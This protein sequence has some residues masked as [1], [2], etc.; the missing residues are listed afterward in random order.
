MWIRGGGTP[1]TFGE[2]DKV[3]GLERLDV[4]LH[5]TIAVIQK[6]KVSRILLTNPFKGFHWTL[7]LLVGAAVFSAPIVGTIAAQAAPDCG[8][9]VSHSYDAKQNITETH[10]A[11]GLTILSKEVHAAPVVYFS[12]WY[13]VGSRN[14][15]SGETGLSH[16]LEHMMF[17]GT[18][19]LPPGS[20]DHLFL[21]NGGEINASTANDRTEY[22]ELIASDRLELAVRVEADRME[23]SAFDPLQLK[24]E[25]TVVRSELEGDNNDPNYDLYTN[26]FEPMEFVESPY[27]WPA[28]GWRSDVEAVANRRD[29]IYAYYK[30]HYM[31]NNAFVVMVGDFDTKKAV[32][33]CQKYFGVYSPGHLAQ[34]HI[35]PEPPQEGERRAIL[36]RPGTTAAIIM[37]FHVP[38]VGTKDHYVFDVL[39]TLLSGGRSDRLYQDLVETGI[40][41]EADADNED[42]IDPWAFTF[43]VSVRN[44]VTT[45]AAEDAI[46]KEITRLQTTPVSEDELQRAIND[47]EASYVYTNDS[48]SSQADLIGS[49]EIN[50]SYRYQDTYLDKIKAITAA[51]IQAAAQKY[52]IANNRCVAIY[53]PTPLPPGA[54]PPAQAGEKDFGAAPPITDPRQKAIIAALD[55]KFNSG[56]STTSSAQLPKPTRVV[57]PNGLTLIVEENHANPTVAI[58]GRVI[59]GSMFDPDNRWGTAGL[60]AAMLSRGTTSAD[61][62][63]LALKLESV[64]ANV[65]FASGKEETSIGGICQSKDFGLTI[66]TMADELRN[67]IFPTDQLEKLRGETLSGLEEAR[68]DTGGTGGAGTDATISFMDALY[69]KGHP[70]W[71]PTIDEQEAAVKGL[72]QS[73]LMSFYQQ[74]YRPDTTILVVVGDVKTADVVNEIKSQFGDWTNPS[75]PTPTIAIPDVPLPTTAPP[76]ITI[77]VPGA[78]QTSILWGYPGQVKRQDKDFYAV[79]LMNYILGG[80]TFGSRLGKTIRDE[81]GLAYSVDSYFDA[82]HG[83]GPFEVFLGTNPHNANRAIGFLHSL[84]QQMK[85]GGVTSD[86]VVNAKKYITGSYPIRLETSEGVAQQLLVSEDFDLGLDYIQKRAS[87][88]DNVTVAQVNTAAKK[89][90]H[91]DKAVLVISGAAPQ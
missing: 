70:Y 19:D 51:D 52:L 89:Y 33:L 9:I 57:L 17:K 11:N 5:G 12:A 72:T 68:Q 44:G 16:I 49:S 62:L 67:S 21:E 23:N 28:I 14:E 20:I 45:Q 58:T 18:K 46:D 54:P 85:T 83:A 1:P 91:P 29:V 13:R 6:V 27:H 32:A 42:H 56:F 35:T 88:Y 79:T 15:I 87:L 55:K 50:S 74:Y 65:N 25:M 10:L 73:D 7:P 22:H 80:D 64:G 81:N 4:Q 84:T 3:H 76:T 60:T 59:S 53:D 26:V 40:A 38:G 47:I 69:P 43:D 66:S 82:E 34:H 30:Q 78:P 39:S 90:L 41:N 24:H 63:H 31:P 75:S 86:E 48:V 8:K 36:R 71:A 77:S 61:A 37:G 2:T